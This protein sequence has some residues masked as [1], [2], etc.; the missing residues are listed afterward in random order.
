MSQIHKMIKVK[1][2]SFS[3]P[4]NEKQMKKIYTISLFLDLEGDWLPGHLQ[5]MNGLTQWLS[6]QADTIDG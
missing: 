1:F 2:G 3:S 4:N 5:E 6:F